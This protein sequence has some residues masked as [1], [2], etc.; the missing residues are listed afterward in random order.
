M[1]TVCEAGK[2]V[3]V[4]TEGEGIKVFNPSPPKQIGVWGQESGV[5]VHKLLPVKESG[6]VFALTSR[7]VEV[8]E[9]SLPSSDTV[10]TL[11]P[12]YSHSYLELTL[13]TGLVAPVRGSQEATEL[14]CCPHNGGQFK[15][16]D[17]TDSHL[18]GAKDVPI[19]N[20]DLQ[21]EPQTRHMECCEV[22]GENRIVLADRHHLLMW[23]VETK[24]MDKTFDC[25][26][27]CREL[28][29][30]EGVCMCVF[31]CVCLS[32]MSSFHSSKECGH[33]SA[34]CEGETVHRNNGRS[35]FGHQLVFLGNTPPTP[36]SRQPCAL[37]AS[38][39]PFPSD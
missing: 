14:W 20:L 4:G 33:F 32:V 24:E 16:F 2:R 17:G 15:V 10:I 1:N 9:G 37:P 23:D 30:D 8:F 34:S 22:G 5:V 25:A 36:W 3:W 19:P 38:H 26:S 35:H 39:K 18:H 31:E 11:T 29:G 21:S 13:S 12:C 7:G 28:Y 27:A 6:L